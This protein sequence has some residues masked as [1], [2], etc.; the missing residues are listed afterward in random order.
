MTRT[1]NG[2]DFFDGEPVRFVGRQSTR[3]P[4]LIQRAAAALALLGGILGTATA[5]LA[6]IAWHWHDPGSQAA[7]D[8][9]LK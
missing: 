1:A 3:G 7:A 5:H 8:A 2:A 4:R 6:L 9:W